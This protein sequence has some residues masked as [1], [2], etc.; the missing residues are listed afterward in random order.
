MVALQRSQGQRCFDRGSGEMAR[1]HLELTLT[2]EDGVGACQIS[3][4]CKP[5]K[6]TGTVSHG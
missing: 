1:A 5:G 3:V 4:R 6:Q 2:L